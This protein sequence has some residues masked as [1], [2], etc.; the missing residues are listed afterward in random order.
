MLKSCQWPAGFAGI[1]RFRWGFASAA[2]A[3]AIA[4]CAMS[5]AEYRVAHDPSQTLRTQSEAE[6]AFLI[7]GLFG[8]KWNQYDRRP[9]VIHAELPQY[10]KSGRRAGAQGPVDCL[11]TIAPSGRVSDVSIL[12]SPDP[13]LSDEVLRA[14]RAWVFEPILKDGVAV[15]VKVRYRYIY[16]LQ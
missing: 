16:R 1:M 6:Q 4:G 10:P 9:R 14:A 7:D 13:L 12:Q 5:P 15:E 8:D 11:V 2:V 3:T